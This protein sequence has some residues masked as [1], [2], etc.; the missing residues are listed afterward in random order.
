MSYINCKLR[1]HEKKDVGC[2]RVTP[3]PLGQPGRRKTRPGT[4]SGGPK[5][6]TRNL[7]LYI[8]DDVEMPKIDDTYPKFLA[9]S[10]TFSTG[11]L[12]EELFNTSTVLEDSAGLMQDEVCNSA[13][14]DEAGLPKTL[15]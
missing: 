6:V 7:N 11:I 12:D 4:R 15:R 13:S 14:L 8:T 10:P 5:T 2:R 3:Y 1:D 9:T